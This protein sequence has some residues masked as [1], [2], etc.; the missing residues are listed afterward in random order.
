MYMETLE[1]VAWWLEVPALG[2]VA[3]EKS[4]TSESK[5]KTLKGLVARVTEITDAVAKVGYD[6]HR[7]LASEPAKHS[8]ATKSDKVKAASSSEKTAKASAKPKTKAAKPNAKTVSP[9]P[10]ESP[11]TKGVKATSSTKTEKKLAASTK[12]AKKAKKVK[13]PAN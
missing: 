8:V 12:K 4:V 13:E 7:L 2:R 10:A 11:K 3:S 9:V 1:Q 5:A 6:F